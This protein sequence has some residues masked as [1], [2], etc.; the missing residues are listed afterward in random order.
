MFYNFWNPEPK[1][2]ERK[3]DQTYLIEELDNHYDNYEIN[4]LETPD[5]D[6][7]KKRWTNIKGLDGDI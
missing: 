5:N 7:L 1:L 3:E 6:Y 2:T 4:D